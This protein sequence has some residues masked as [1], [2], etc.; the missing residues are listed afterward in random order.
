MDEIPGKYLF[1]LDDNL[2][3]YSAQSKDRAKQIFEGMIRKGLKKRWWMQT[4][5]NSADDEELLR[6]AAR[7]GCMF[8]FVGFESISEDS[9]R[10]MKK[11]VN[12]KIGVE[13]YRRV[14]KAFHRHGIGIVRGVHQRKRSRVAAVLPRARK[15]PGGGEHRHGPAFDPDAASRARPSWNE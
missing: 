13:N 3:G 4:S 12:L 11:G 14:V 9:L 6:L 1:F 2:V 5:I 10:D 8:A 7:S 15:V